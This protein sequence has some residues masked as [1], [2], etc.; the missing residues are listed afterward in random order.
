MTAGFYKN[1]FAVGEAADPF[2]LYDSGWFYLYYT[3]GRKL[4]AKRSRDLAAWEDIGTVF[5]PQ[6]GSWIVRHLWAP[7]VMRWRD[8][9][10]YMYVTASGDTCPEGTTLDG[11]DGTHVC[12]PVLD[13]V[14]CAVLVSDS[15]AGPFRQWTGARPNITRYRHGEK[16]GTGDTV[17]IAT[18]PHFDFA[19]APAGWAE[20]AA[21]YAHNGTNIFSVLDAS[22]FVDDDGTL[23]LYFVRSHDSNRAVHGIWGMKMLDPV[24]PDY[25]TMVKLTE[26]RQLYLDGPLSPDGYMDGKLNEGVFVHKRNDKYYM[27]YSAGDGYNTSLAIGDEP[28]G[29]FEKLLP[30]YRNPVLRVSPEFGFYNCPEGWGVFGAGHGMLFRAGEEE[31]FAALTT[32]PKADGTTHRTAMFDRLVWRYDDRLGYELP[33]INGPTRDT[34]QPAP[35]VAT[36]YADVAPQARVTVNGADAGVLV[37]G[38]IPVLKRDDGHTLLCDGAHITLTFDAPRTVTAVMV[39]NA[40]TPVN[41]FSQVD[42]IVVEGGGKRTAFCD[43]A[44]PREYCIGDVTDARADDEVALQPAA[45]WAEHPLETGGILPAGAVVIRFEPTAAERIDITVTQKLVQNG[46]GIGISEVVVLGK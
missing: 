41:A 30:A 21:T 35:A 13:G 32:R 44:F 20:N 11:K 28:L 29:Q 36:G 26:P 12:R 22:P 38:V 43:V 34:L 4:T 2:V 46:A 7:E 14:T 18:Y 8:G 15:P 16:I 27:F 19:N 39:Y 24:T 6:A 1:D 33:V 5:A 42:E 25:T 3:G 37:D 10:Y 45:Y 9:K 23:Y 40:R 31:F 17:T